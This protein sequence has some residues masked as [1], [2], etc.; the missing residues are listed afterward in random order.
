MPL[1]NLSY[2]KVS[3]RRLLGK[4]M[5]NHYFFLMTSIYSVNDKLILFKHQLVKFLATLNLPIK[6]LAQSR[7][8]VNT[9]EKITT[10]INS[11]QRPASQL[12]EQIPPN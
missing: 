11:A 6:H 1:C 10:F 5:E 12:F 3:Q 8:T 2:T 4:H 7:D 9:Y